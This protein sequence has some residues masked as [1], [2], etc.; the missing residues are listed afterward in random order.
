MPLQASDLMWWIQVFAEVF[1]DV[2]SGVVAETLPGHVEGA[3]QCQVSLRH[4][5]SWHVTI[6][7]ALRRGRDNASYIPKHIY[8]K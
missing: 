2:L 8:Q 7:S 1:C 3:V 6:V 4:A 5:S